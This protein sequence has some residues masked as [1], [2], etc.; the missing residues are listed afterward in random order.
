[1]W[2]QRPLA[3]LACFGDQQLTL[4]GVHEGYSYVVPGFTE[5]LWLNTE[6]CELLPFD[7]PSDAFA[8]GSHH[9]PLPPAARHASGYDRPR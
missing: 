7:V 4:E 3:L 6:S 1:M 8:F 9:L 2:R 5:P